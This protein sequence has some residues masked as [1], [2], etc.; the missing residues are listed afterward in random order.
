MSFSSVWVSTCND[1]ANMVSSEPWTLFELE[2]QQDACLSGNSCQP[3]GRHGQ[4][5]SHT[6][7]LVWSYVRHREECFSSISASLRH[8]QGRHH[9]DPS[10]FGLRGDL[11][12]C[13]RAEPG[14]TWRYLFCELPCGKYQTFCS[15]WA[16]HEEVAQVHLQRAF[17]GVSCPGLWCQI[18]PAIQVPL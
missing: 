4:R 3:N 9:L 5:W 7:V 18:K 2:A 17:L 12:M 8:R 14:L 11:I 16:T 6:Q 15:P 13:L 1:Q 10:G